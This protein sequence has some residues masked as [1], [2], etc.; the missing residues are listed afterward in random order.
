MADKKKDEA[1]AAPAAESAAA[2]EI[3]LLDKVIAEGRMA[4]DDSQKALA[5]DLVGEFVHQVVDEGMTVGTD[6]LASIEDQIA[7]ID[8]ILSAQLNEILH[9][10]ELQ[11]LEASWRGLHYLVMNTETGT[12]LKLRLLNVVQE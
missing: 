5:R 4:R 7:K 8:A 10:P 3:T 11:R 2:T 6:T 1:A 12:K 9:D